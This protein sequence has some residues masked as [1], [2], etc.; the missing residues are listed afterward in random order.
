MVFL[1]T[2]SLL[3]VAIWGVTLLE[4]RFEA[5]WFLPPDSYLNKWFDASKQYFPSEGVQVKLFLTAKV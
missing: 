2:S 5:Q 1:A 4:T 3:G